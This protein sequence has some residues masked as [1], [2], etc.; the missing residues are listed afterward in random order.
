M[1]C[2]VRTEWR[3][4]RLATFYGPTWVAIASTFI[5][6]AVTGRKILKGRRQ[7]SKFAKSSGRAKV[8]HQKVHPKLEHTTQ[9]S[10]MSDSEVGLTLSSKLDA[11]EDDREST[12]IPSGQPAPT[13]NRNT[14]AES[15]SAAF[16]YARCALLFFIA[17]LVVW[18]RRFAE[19]LP[20]LSLLAFF[21]IKVNKKADKFAQI[22]SS[23]NRLYGM[24]N[25][26]HPNFVMSLVAATTNPLQGFWN[27]VIYS[28]TSFPAVK[29][30]FAKIQLR[31]KRANP[32]NPPW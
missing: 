10:T 2:W 25:P 24:I 5:I 20:F 17:L 31:R 30:L 6:Y 21:V 3:T 27:C 7:L 22:P 28:A 32:T 16:A 29:A 19:K 1:W 8:V 9:L 23:I 15:H 13:Q 18:V 14:L 11:S 4:L 26:L 12:I